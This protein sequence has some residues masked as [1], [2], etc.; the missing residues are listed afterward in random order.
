LI[1]FHDD[2]LVRTTNAQTMYPDRR[3]WTT[4]AF[5]LAEIRALD[6]GSW[7]VETDPFGQIAAGAV[8]PG[9]L[10]SYVCESVPTLREALIYTQEAGW[11]VNLELKRVPAADFPLAE[12]VTA[13]VEELLIE[14][15]RI[16]ISSYD[17]EQLRQVQRLS[18]E[19][20]VQALVVN[21]QGVEHDFEFETYNVR[22][23]MV[24]EEQVRALSERGIAVNL[25]TVNGERDMRR[26]IAA[27]AAG[28][29]TDFPQRLKAVL[30]D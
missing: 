24:S 7:F 26:F 10:L 4:T 1:L 5:V 2:T 20:E 15:H 16:I 11:R 27:G 6:A 9:E 14:T 19:I 3:P 23:D 12:R 8:T 21:L 22:T 30:Q 17:H 29:F 18:P 28:L 13:L 25:F